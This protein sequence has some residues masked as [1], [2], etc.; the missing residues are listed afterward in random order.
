MIDT[1]ALFEMPDPEPGPPVALSEPMSADRRRNLRQ[2]ET[3]AAG[4][5][6][7]NLVAAP[8]Y[9]HP[10]TVDQT[11]TRDDSAGR[12]LTCGSCVFRE[13]EQHNSRKYSKCQAGGGRRVSSGAAT[14]VRAW[15]PACTLWRQR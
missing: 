12:N 7:L 4:G 10:F 9:R 5:H 1:D 2:A 6:P 13:V 11:Y 14:D 3:I 8:V 15:W